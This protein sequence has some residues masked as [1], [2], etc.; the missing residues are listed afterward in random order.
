MS[1]E[2]LKKDPIQNQLYERSQQEGIQT[3]WERE[4]KQQP[5]CGFGTL[6][7]CC[8]NCNLG[9]C[10][11]D[12]F[13]EGATRGVCGADADT[14]SA[15]NLVRHIAAGASCHSDHG[16]EIVKTLHLTA[17]G[18]TKFYKVR[19]EEKLKAVAKEYKV[20]VDGRTV[21]TIAKELA[22]KMFA[23]F[24]QQEGELALIQRAP[25]KQ[26]KIWRKYS[27][28]PRGIDREPVEALSRTHIGV[29]NDYNNLMQHGMRV[30]LADGW[31]GSMIATELTDILFGKPSPKRAKANL[32]VLKEDQVNLIVHG[33][34]P[35][36]SEVICDASSD[37]E[38]ISL[39][40]EHGALGINLA[41]ICCTANEI[42]V[43]RGYPVAGD[44][45]QQELAIMTGAV[46]L[47]LVDLQCIMPSLSELG[48]CFH[49]K[50]VSTSEKARFPGMNHVEFH[51]EEAL[52]IAKAI[53]RMAIE[54]FPNRNKEKV[55]IPKGEGKDLIPGFTT[56]YVFDM[57]GG[58]Y[59][60]SYKPL[61]EAII[62]GRIRGVAG[63][64]GCD[65]PKM[66]S[67]ASHVTL[68]KELIKNDVLVV[69]TGCSAL[70]CG[71]AGLLT[72]EAAFDYA[73]KGLK[74][75]CEAVG[76]PPVL[77]LGSCVDNSRIL[78]ACCEMV[79]EGG[80]GRSLDE[81]PVAG[82]APEWMSEKA[83]AIG[84]YFV[85]SGLLV[86]LGEPLP[87]YGSDNMTKYVFEDVEKITGGKWAFDKDPLKMA[88]IMIEHIDSKRKALSL[89]PMMYESKVEVGR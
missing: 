67:S 14:I 34:V 49:T 73:G 26:K 32:S 65:N 46:D 18:K 54:N 2:D 85:A 82:A 30:A 57:L 21:E 50:I 35:L 19:D 83:I 74:E 33:H 81:L 84:W 59:R 69:Q 77:H 75:V 31:G 5:H 48:N 10:R 44:F 89:K 11:I 76:C 42:L 55:C 56:E 12:P 29:D 68:V 13:G 52:P 72:P 80:I 58:R 45:L 39:A 62:N 63:V 23:E 51:E 70:S 43:R 16:R 86:V 38:L 20:N 37:P 60:P 17:V 53:V 47:M 25:E 22:E 78:T 66:A 27:L 28:M 24:G 40:K 88:K 6:G 71:R 87:V 36:L 1:R 9:P 61:N 64:V 8:K 3:I 7:L 15:R 79:K 4:E 41:G